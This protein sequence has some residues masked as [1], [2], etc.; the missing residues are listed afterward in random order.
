MKAKVSIMKSLCLVMIGLISV[1]EATVPPIPKGIFCMPPAEPNGFPNQILNDSRIVGLDIVDDWADVEATEGVYDW[2]TLDSQLAQAAASGKKVLFGIVSG[3]INIPDWLLANYPDIQ[4]F[5]FTDTN[6]YHSTYG[7]TL[8]IPVF[9]DPIFLAKKIALIQAAGAHFAS[10]PNI[11]IV[12]S[13]FANATTEDWNIPD[14]PEDIANWQAAGYTT[15]L[16]VNTGEMIIDATMAAFPNQNITMSIGRNDT[17]LDPTED[18]LSQ[19]IVDYATTT[20]ARFIT[21][22]YA[23]AANTPDPQTTTAL[24]NWQIFFNQCPNVSA[25]MLWFVSGDTTYRMNGGVAGDPATVLLNAINI[26]THYGTQFQEIYEV[27]LTNSALDAVLN[28]ASYALTVTPGGD[29]PP[30]APT[31]L[32]ATSTGANLVNLTWSDNAN[33]ELGYRIESK[34]EAT[35]TYDVLT[36]LDPNTTTATINSGLIEGTQYYFRVQAV[37]AGGRSAYS[38]EASVATVLIAPGNLTA[39]PLSASQMLLNWSDNSGT[40]T[41]FRIERS[42]VTDTNFTEI[43]T[44]GANTTTFTDS[45]LNEASK[46]YYRV[47]AYNADTTSGY[48][49]E[50]QAT[51]LY[52][53]PAAPSGLT[54]TSLLTNRVSISWTDNSGDETGFKVQRK[55]GA[56]GTYATIA[57]TPANVTAY[58]DNSLTDGTVY[59]YR[60]AAT[61][62]AG[63]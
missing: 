10:N 62:P 59:Y 12:G 44:V 38:N 54:V 14:A 31:N 45:G 27:D 40:E 2:S 60:V 47:R 56:T 36:T 35:G 28:F 23:L 51:T 11:V 58:N 16:M 33:N 61:N 50:Y 4:T 21:A 42:P 19:T 24:Y 55:I 48:S 8:T 5:R 25:Q 15:D 17:D 46:Y 20:Y 57:T 29:P 49:N 6:P 26:G 34:I 32:S 43:G 18:Y 3:G 13:A 52:N 63:D 37:N 22:K 41:G 7:E 39:Q 1:A 9:W 30:A 53:I